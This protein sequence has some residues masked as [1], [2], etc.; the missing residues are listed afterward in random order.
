MQK[1]KIYYIL[2]VFSVILMLGAAI[3]NN[4]FSYSINQIAL[5]SQKKISE[6]QER[7]KEILNLLLNDSLTR[8]RVEFEDLYKQE[9][10]GVYYFKNCLL[11]TSPSPRD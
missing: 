10:I 5:N 3:L 9:N 11:Y 6:K 8:R 4:R 1:G 2:L 7:S